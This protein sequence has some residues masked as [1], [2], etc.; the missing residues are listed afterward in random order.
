MD[1]RG[2]NFSYTWA[3][4]GDTIHIWFGDRDSNNFFQAR[5]REDGA[6][7]SG[8]WQWSVGGSDSGHANM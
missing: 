8:N 3:I 7:S 2:S 4:D 5:F 6:S 1:T